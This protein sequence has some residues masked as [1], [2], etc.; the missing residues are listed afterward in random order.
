MAIYKIDPLHSVIDFKVK[1]LMISNVNGKF[2]KFDATII[3]EEEDFSDADIQFE[4]DADS[5][6]TNI[7]DRDSH[8]KSEDFFDS[9]KFPKITFKSTGVKKEQDFYIIKGNLKIKNVEKEIE[10]KGYYNGNAIDLHGVNKYG[11]DLKG[12]INRSDYDLKFNATGGKGNS[13]VGEEV[14]ITIS[15]QMFRS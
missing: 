13:L 4:C 12:V 14:K 9:E 6:S 15:I 3:S 7:S 11:F 2:T 10:I 5:I 8:L 1:H